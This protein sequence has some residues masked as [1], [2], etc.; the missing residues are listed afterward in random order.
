MCWAAVTVSRAPQ[1]C[2]LHNTRRFLRHGTSLIL[3]DKADH[4]GRGGY[5]QGIVAS[6]RAQQIV[7][8]LTHVLSVPH[9]NSETRVSLSKCLCWCAPGGLK[10]FLSYTSRDSLRGYWFYLNHGV[11]LGWYHH[12]LFTEMPHSCCS[13]PFSLPGSINN[14]YFTSPISFRDWLNH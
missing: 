8:C 11:W 13:W 5:R 2:D 12:S 7:F 14:S 10:T 3:T 6:L 1:V 4:R 9:Q